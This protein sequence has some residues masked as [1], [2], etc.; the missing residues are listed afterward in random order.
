MYIDNIKNFKG[1]NILEITQNIPTM[2]TINET[3]Q[4]TGIAKYRIRKLC[5]SGEIV[6]LKAGRKWLINCEKFIEFLNT[7]KSSQPFE[8]SSA[9]RKIKE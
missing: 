8:E 4:K 2:L 9:I 3:A 1:G 6:S 7:N 5:E